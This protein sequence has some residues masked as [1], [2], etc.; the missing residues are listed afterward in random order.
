MKEMTRIGP[1]HL[2]Q[3]R[4]S[5]FPDQVRDRLLSS[6]SALQ[7]RVNLAQFLRYSLDLRAES[8]GE[9]GQYSGNSA[10]MQD[11]LLHRVVDEIDTPALYGVRV[12]GV[13]ILGI[14]KGNPAPVS[15][16]IDP[17]FLKQRD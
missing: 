3:V 6:G 14:V 4:G 13:R 5:T 1:W 8:I 16:A 12:V 7:R 2:A 11:F 9:L 17:V 10:H 15:P